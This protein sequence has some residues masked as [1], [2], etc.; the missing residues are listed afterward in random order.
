MKRFEVRHVVYLWLVDYLKTHNGDL[1]LAIQ[2]MDPR[3][4][5]DLNQT[6]DRSHLGCDKE[7]KGDGV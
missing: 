5:W 7:T 1:Y 4:S 6:C 2:Y 3:L